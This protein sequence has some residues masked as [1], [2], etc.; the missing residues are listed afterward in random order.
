M[1]WVFKMD[2]GELVEEYVK[3]RQMWGGI[4]YALSLKWILCKLANRQFRLADEFYT[5]VSQQRAYDWAT[6]DLA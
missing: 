6:S 5:S 3:D 4:C 2:Q 1:N